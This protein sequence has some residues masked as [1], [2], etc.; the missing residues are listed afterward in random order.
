MAKVV[1]GS[2]SSLQ[3]A[4]DS[5]G[6]EGMLFWLFSFFFGESQYVST[7]KDTGSLGPIC[8]AQRRTSPGHGV[9]PISEV[10]WSSEDSGL[11]A[12]FEP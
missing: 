2:S 8:A 7:R 9:L 3:G 11:M 10:T 5:L 4:G 1:G 12:V 6:E